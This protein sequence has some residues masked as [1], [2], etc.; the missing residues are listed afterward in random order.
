MYDTKTIHYL[1]RLQSYWISRKFESPAWFTAQT[2]D[3][4]VRLPPISSMVSWA[5]IIDLFSSNQT[6]NTILAC[7]THCCLAQFTTNVGVVICL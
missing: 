3:Q 4:M 6:T 5:H 1:T 7:G 2:L